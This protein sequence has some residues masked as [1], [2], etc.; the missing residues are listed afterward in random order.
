[1]KHSSSG[2]IFVVHL[3]LICQS[4]AQVKGSKFVIRIAPIE[5]KSLWTSNSSKQIDNS[6]AK[7]LF[8]ALLCDFRQQ[9]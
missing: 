6:S 2:Y 5:S 1:M 8:L 3:W 9:T 7:G 4:E